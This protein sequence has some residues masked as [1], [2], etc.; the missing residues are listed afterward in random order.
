MVDL[1]DRV[2]PAIVLGRGYTALGTLRSLALAGIPTYV[3]CPAGDLATH[4]RSYRPP[5]GETS[6]D[7]SVDSQ[8]HEILRAMP[9][10]HAV[11]IPGA[12]DAALWVADLV[13]SDLAARF[14]ASSSS[15]ETLE[16]LQDKARF[17]D[18]LAHV[19]IPHPRT[20]TINDTSDVSAIPF[21]ELDRVF[22]KPVN[23]QQFSRCTGIKG[24]WANNRKQFQEIW[25][26][27]DAQGFKVIAQEY[28]PGGA[29][30]HY[31][32]DGFCDR[33]GVFTGL[34]ARRRIRIF[35]PDFGNSSYCQSIPLAHVQSAIASVLEVLTRLRYRGIFSAEFKRD[36]RD[37]KFRMLEVNTRAWWYVEF[38]ARCGVNVC[39]MAF[40][41][42]EGLPVSKAPTDYP[43]GIGCVNLVGDVKS[44]FSQHPFARIPLLRALGEWTRAHY[45]VFRWD[46]PG[47]GLAVGWL[48]LRR[49][50]VRVWGLMH[51]RKS[52]A[53][54]HPR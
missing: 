34:F 21:D 54:P 2:T 40:Q 52:T 15:R 48:G 5:P 49:L 50:M 42:A 20:F 37:G 24:V 46:D 9:L 26:R 13:Q 45:H 19:G 47:P 43:T 30:D 38:A 22:V 44:V 53:I 33:N 23:S 10:E 41:D 11:L 31:F 29:D 17:G 1:D 39:Q 14:R 27:F 36:S 18:F 51:R 6:W 7:G 16:I 3:A 8:T 28:V 25:A 4:S 35:P 32:I 12:D